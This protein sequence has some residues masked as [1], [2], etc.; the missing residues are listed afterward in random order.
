MLG[1]PASRGGGDTSGIP[2]ASL[3]PGVGLEA[4]DLQPPGRWLVVFGFLQKGR[5][6]RLLGQHFLTSPARDWLVGESKPLT[7]P[8]VVGGV[9]TSFP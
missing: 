7:D 3:V 1:S 5:V 8:A 9:F 4:F 2:K 6:G